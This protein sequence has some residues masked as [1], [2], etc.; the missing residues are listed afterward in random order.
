M[1]GVR[2][3]CLGLYPC[4]LRKRGEVLGA[5]LPSE[6]MYTTISQKDE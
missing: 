4:V 3:G 5:R 2:D 1:F 6:V